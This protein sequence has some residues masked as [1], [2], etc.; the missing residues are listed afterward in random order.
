MANEGES[1]GR[2]PGLPYR[3]RAR[4]HL[5]RAREDL[6][7]GDP[8]STLAACLFLRMA[9]EALAYDLLEA[10]RAEVDF[11]AM[12]KWQPG[13]VIEE[14]LEIDAGADRGV[15]LALHDA[16][17]T[18][19]LSGE[20]RRLKADWIA[21]AHGTRLVFCLPAIHR[22]CIGS[23]FS[24]Q[25]STN[26]S[27]DIKSCPGRIWPRWL[28]WRLCPQRKPSRY[29]AARHRLVPYNSMS[30]LNAAVSS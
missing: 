4:E 13:K 19:I 1:V 14:L 5:A 20:E 10:Y 8:Y 25:L 24:W 23:G 28:F 27:L 15:S 18:E 7:R 3:P 17:G 21:E 22:L 12:R 29:C 11:A 6:A 30:H 16:D 2:P 9:I 26:S